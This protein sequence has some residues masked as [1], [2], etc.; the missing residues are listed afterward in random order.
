TAGGGVVQH[1]AMRL[2]G[3]D[4]AGYAAVF[5]VEAIGLALCVPLLR[6]VDVT[7]FAKEVA[8]ASARR[9]ALAMGWRV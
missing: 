3:G 9:S 8:A 6:G 7:T 1:L 2:S 5:A 4:A